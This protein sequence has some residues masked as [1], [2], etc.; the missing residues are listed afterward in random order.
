MEKSLVILAGGVEVLNEAKKRC[1][2]KATKPGFDA[3]P[4]NACFT[5]SGYSAGLN[6]QALTAS[7]IL[8]SPSK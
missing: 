2:V 5:F 6:A 3:V 1:P 4:A 8:E 7:I